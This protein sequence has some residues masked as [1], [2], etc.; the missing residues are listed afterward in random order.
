MSLFERFPIVTKEIFYKFSNIDNLGITQFLFIS[1]F[2]AIVALILA[3]HSS[4]KEIDL[5]SS[6]QFTSK[7]LENE[8]YSLPFRLNQAG[9][10]ALVFTSTF[11]YIIG[12]S[13]SKLPVGNFTNQINP[14][15]F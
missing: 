1:I 13:I 10:M 12:S 15:V 2:F 8:K 6:K 9:V 5:L 4:V 7:F 3:F 14:L 11:T